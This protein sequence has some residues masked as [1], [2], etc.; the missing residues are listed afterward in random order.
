MSEYNID[1]M[2]ERAKLPN[3]TVRAHVSFE[4]NQLAKQRGYHWN[5]SSKVWTRTFKEDQ[6]EGS[7]RF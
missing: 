2:I 6:V 1:E 7:V 4:N 5:P 3:V